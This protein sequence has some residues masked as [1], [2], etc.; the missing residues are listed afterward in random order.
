LATKIA[1]LRM[2]TD[3]LSA[4]ARNI[5]GTTR[6]GIE[7]TMDSQMGLYVTRA[8]RIFADADFRQAVTAAKGDPKRTQEIEDILSVADAE[9]EGQYLTMRTEAYITKEG[10]P[11][12]EAE[13]MAK[14][15]LD[16]KNASGL[17]VGEQARIEFL[18]QYEGGGAVP[19]MVTDPEFLQ[20]VDRNLKR[21]QSLSEPIRK[22]LGEYGQEE[23]ANLLLHTYAT[24][25]GIASH[26]MLLE[27]IKTQG[28]MGDADSEQW[29]FSPEDIDA[30]GG[31][32]IDGLAKGQAMLHE[33]GF[34]PIQIA[35]GQRSIYNP[36]AGHYGPR[37][38]VDAI[39]RVGA[40]EELD[41]TVDASRTLVKVLTNG[42]AK[43]TGASMGL[44]TLGSVGHF[45]R[46]VISQPFM[47][48]SQGRPIGLLP[49]MTS[50]LAGELKGLAFRSWRGLSDEVIDNQRLEYINL[51]IIGDE[52]RAGVLRDLIRGKRTTDD[53]QSEA[54]DLFAKLPEGMAKGTA[55]FD[56]AT[57]FIGRVEAA[58]EAFYKIAYYEDTLATLRAAKKDGRGS[59]RGVQISMMSDYDLKREAAEQVRSTAPIQGRTLPVV[60]QITKSGPGLL[61]AP[62]LRWKSEMVRTPVNTLVLARM[63]M[64]SGNPVLVARG[65][66][67]MIGM[68][69]MVIL[70][71][72]LPVLLSKLLGG[73]GD[74]EDEALRDSMP[75]YLRNHSFFYF[76]KDGQLTSLDLTYVNPFS[77]LADPWVRAIAD[78]V[79]PSG[80]AAKAASRL[81]QAGIVETFLDDQILAGTVMSAKRNMD[82]TT[83][84]PIWIEG[85]DDPGA[86][87]LKTLKF[88][89]DDAFAPRLIADSIKAWQA[90]GKDASLTRVTPGS[91]LLSGIY[92]V[93][94]H[95]VD[96]EQQLRRYLYN[97]QQKYDLVAKNKFKA[98]ADAP[99]SAE[100]MQELYAYEARVKQ[101]INSDVYR[102]IQG[103]AGMG[104]PTPYIANQMNEMRFGRERT[105]LLF[106]QTMAQPELSEKYVSALMA[107]PYGP[108]RI[109][110]MIGEKR[111]T[112]KLMSLDEVR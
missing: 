12:D 99:M 53:I 33:R 47:A 5:F 94:T 83:G 11:R 17:S 112:P 64:A 41:A 101:R 15:D 36:L 37:D 26:A 22:L 48:W 28:R 25:S 45:L 4:Q 32:G 65:A 38:L 78:L 97:A 3:E 21:R 40:A 19:R 88:I 105:R 100:D 96:P 85:V 51:G 27:Q 46:N 57:E 42:A 72:A 29:L 35:R 81:V 43:A 62:F 92:P 49:G 91:I 84:E 59:I 95:A 34:A 86:A 8:Y 89:M 13:R 107:K 16:R 87:A 31:G 103:F 14:E 71:G 50:A 6:P 24:V 68:S 67:R 9:F 54:I 93:R 108:A 30:L 20:L 98:L 66:K 10:R 73:I 39:A 111:K 56:K 104:V 61:L 106:M 18:R 2:I 55:L 79:S 1:E 76:M 70:S 7:I 58:T 69:S 23:G 44:K 63:E 60:K 102:K 74:E 52:V 82:P 75:E 77:Q 80:G 90:T 109:D 110:A